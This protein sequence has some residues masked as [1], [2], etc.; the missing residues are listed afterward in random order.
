MMKEVA[1]YD[2]KYAVS[3]DGTVWTMQPPGGSGPR[4]LRPYVNTGGYLRVN[5][6]RGGKT[7]H[8]Y[9]HRLVAEAFLPNPSGFG[10]VNHK[11]ANPQNNAADNLEWCD[12]GYNIRFSRAAGNQN[13]IP[14]RA[15]NVLT[16]EVRVFH[17]LKLAGIELFGKW[18]A[19]RYHQQKKG[20]RFSVGAWAFEV[21]EREI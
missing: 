9:V 17:N 6:R 4:A 1:G 13:D 8:K 5:L 20:K 2:G 19:L 18:W 7:E 11:D 10:V 12:Q 15:V 3:G 14:V 21:I 16:G